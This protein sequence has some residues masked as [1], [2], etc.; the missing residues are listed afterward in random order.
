MKVFKCTVLEDVRHT[1]VDVDVA[2]LA[3]LYFGSET[4]FYLLKFCESTLLKGI[5]RG[6]S[7]NMEERHAAISGSLDQL[8]AT[9]GHAERIIGTARRSIFRGMR[10]VGGEAFKEAVQYT[11]DAL[12]TVAGH[13][14]G[15]ADNITELLALQDEELELD[16]KI[17]NVASQLALA[18][19]TAAKKA[20]C[21]D[22]GRRVADVPVKKVA[23]LE[24]DELDWA[25]RDLPHFDHSSVDYGEN[26][27]RKGGCAVE[28]ARQHGIE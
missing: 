17:R 10:C 16:R 28:T 22:K 24:N 9:H 19:A 5:K 1:D 23:Q 18:K 6:Y 2:K 21:L 14:Y 26:C 25:Y 4:S 7:L 12:S 27:Q 13:I 15:V 3:L 11:Q 20:S 8:Y